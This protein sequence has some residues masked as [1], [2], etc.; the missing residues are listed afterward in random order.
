MEITPA[1]PEDRQVVDSYGP[2][3]FRIART[4]YEGPVIVLPG[5]VLAWD[6]SD[7]SQL[8]PERLAP[9]FETE[10]AV[11]LLLIG[12]GPRM[13]PPP[14]GLRE[15]A[16]ARGAAIDFMETGAACRTY[17]VLLAEGRQVAA[18]LIPL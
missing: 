4:D 14:K 7:L 2:G 15:A 18:A 13:A 12:L 11:E 3:R 17:N 10:E 1:I 8:A 5:R 9:A 6:V 16:R